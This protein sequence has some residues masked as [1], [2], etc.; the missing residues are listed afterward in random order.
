[1]SVAYLWIKEKKT[2]ILRF[3]ATKHA[4]DR[5]PKQADTTTQ[6]WDFHHLKFSVSP[7]LTSYSSFCLPIQYSTEAITLLHIVVSQTTLPVVQ[8]TVC[9]VQ[10]TV[11]IYTIL[12]ELECVSDIFNACLKEFWSTL[13]CGRRV[14]PG[15]GGPAV[16][17]GGPDTLIPCSATWWSWQA[18]PLWSHLVVRRSYFH[19]F[20]PGGPYAL[21]PWSTAWWS[22]RANHVIRP[23]WTGHHNQ[24]IQFLNNP[25]HDL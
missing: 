10:Q 18:N 20:S 24:L 7:S 4:I 13:P 25:T 6:T 2:K 11:C 15:P 17:P 19:V 16:P 5:I 3:L 22:A 1:M 9:V 12:K 8:P 23:C 21:T 14:G